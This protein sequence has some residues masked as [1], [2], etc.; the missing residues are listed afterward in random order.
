MKRLSLPHWSVNPALL[1]SFALLVLPSLSA[2]D[3]PMHRG[4]DG[5]GISTEEGLLSSGEAKVVWKASLGLGYSTP[6]VSEGKVVVSGHVGNNTDILYCLDE[7]TAEELW[8]YSYPQPLGDLYFQGGTTGTAT[9]DGDHVYQLA[10]QGEFVCLNASTGEV[11]WKKNLQE[12]FGYTLP[13]WGF[14]GAP[15][16]RGDK[17]YLNAGEAGIAL[18]K[19]DGSLIWKSD[20]EEAGYST[21]F[22]FEKN[23]KSY[24]M[25]TNKRFYVCV[26]E[27]TGEKVWEYRWMTRYGVNS[28]DPII[29]GD[30]IFI[31]SAYGKGGV[32]VNWDGTSDPERVWQNREMR[33]QMN[34]CVLIDGYLYGIDG[35]EG[36][37]G[38][39]LKCLEM[40]TGETKWLNED[41]AHGA[42]IAVKDQLVVLTENGELQIGPASPEGFSPT[43]TQQVIGPKVWTVPVYANGHLFCR[44]SAGDLLALK[45]E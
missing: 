5:T 28:A 9:F 3:W 2:A 25:F 37:D 34:A 33:T 18:N 19:A 26:D 22:A 11:I 10:R 15:L 32:L 36:Q 44:N 12:D 24:L 40:A 17:I 45:V 30:T 6:V 21:P 43:L 23:G 13:T 35:N 16:I 27:A 29:S 8:R 31:S 38:T 41:V 4:P 20:D 14:S 39:S 42:V 1:A 7:K